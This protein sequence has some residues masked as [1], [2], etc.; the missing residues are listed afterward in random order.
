ML[1]MFMAMAMLLA[2]AKEEARKYVVAEH[3]RNELHMEENDK[4]AFYEQDDDEYRSAFTVWYWDEEDICTDRYE[5]DYTTEEYRNVLDELYILSGDNVVY[6]TE[7]YVYFENSTWMK[8]HYVH[9]QIKDLHL[10]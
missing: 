1:K 8:W 10:V 7:G 2:K 4:L 6:E 3:I 5:Y 9:M